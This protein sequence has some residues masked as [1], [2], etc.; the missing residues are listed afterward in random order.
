MGAKDLLTGRLL[1]NAQKFTDKQVA[2]T[3]AML[4]EHGV[5]RGASDIHLEPHERFVLVRY[6]IDGTLRGIHKL[7]RAA[8]DTLLAQL[9]TLADLN[10]GETTMPQEGTYQQTVSDQRVDVRV[11]T[12][13][14]LGGEKAVLHISLERGKPAGLGQLGFWGSGLE[15]L[16]QLL[17][18]PH[19]LLAVAGPRHSGINSTLFSLLDNLN[20]PLV[21]IATV[22]SHPKHRLPGVNQTYLGSSGMSMSSGLQAALK[23]DPNI[24]MLGD[25]PDGATAELAIH[26]A[27]TGHLV[28][29]GLRADGAVAAALRLRASGVEPFLLVTALKA[30]VGQRLVR[31]LCPNC[32]E[33]YALSLEEQRDLAKRFG[34]SGAGAFKR[35]HELERSI[36]PAIFGDVKQLSSS[37][38]AIT[39]LWRASNT[40]CDT[41]DRTGYN[42]RIAITEVLTSTPNIQKALL[43]SDVHSVAELQAIA[44]KEGFVPMALDGLIKALR[45]QTTI[46]EVLHAISPTL[47]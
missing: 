44:V 26:A 29:A 4:V 37:P 40:G 7:P 10:P 19:G 39:H 21:S 30:T 36:A 12:M 22:E 6:R 3:L 2:E 46:T 45:G 9:K 13:P 20:S 34:I 47:A 43:S 23:Q 5:R 27:S 16:Q 14:V 17:A 33:R 35:V 1:G 24:I 15:L 42:G 31:T 38:T 32:R 25:V 8:L 11:A 28:L 18:A 41:C